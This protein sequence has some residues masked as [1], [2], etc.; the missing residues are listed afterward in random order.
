LSWD[1]NSVIHM[2]NGGSRCE[3][4]EKAGFGFSRDD[5]SRGHGGP[6]YSQLR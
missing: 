5:G 2:A 4:S 1:L 3:K 6:R